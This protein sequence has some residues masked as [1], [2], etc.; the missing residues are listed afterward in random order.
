MDDSIQYFNHVIISVGVACA[1]LM[2]SAV[3]GYFKI[4]TDCNIPWP[5]INVIQAMAILASFAPLI[6]EGLKYVMG[7]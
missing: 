7:V 1:L 5:V 2:I 4:E 6:Y 3:L